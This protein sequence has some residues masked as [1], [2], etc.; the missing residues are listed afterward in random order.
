MLRLVIY[1]LL[2]FP[3]IA[4]AQEAERP[5][6]KFVVADIET[7]VPV[8]GVI[9]STGDGYR[10]TTNYRGVC[11]IPVT[12]DTLTVAKA[13]YLTERILA[14]EVKDST[15]LIPNS[16]RLSEVTVWGKDRATR[17][18]ENAEKWSREGAS[19]GS[20]P[21]GIA[22]F[23][24]ARMLDA[25]YRRDQKHLKKARESFAKMDQEDEDPIVSA[26]K[27]ALEEERLKKEEQ[28]KLE[29]QKAKLRAEDQQEMQDK[30]NQT[31]TGQ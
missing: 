13:N 9:V 4:S 27:K 6:K 24:L 15:F 12:F 17:L 21:K 5:L 23:D 31:A 16:H 3:L 11:F 20:A 26:Y 8:R 18:Q 25:R 22:A 19:K 28:A 2:L 14:K 30:I 10:D 1:I 7:R 29:E